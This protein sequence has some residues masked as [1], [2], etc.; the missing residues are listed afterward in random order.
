M[1]PRRGCARASWSHTGRRSSR[2]SPRACWPPPRPLYQGEKLAQQLGEEKGLVA[3]VRRTS[4]RNRALTK[5][6]ALSRHLRA[7]R[8]TASPLQHPRRLNLP[9]RR[10][11]GPSPAFLVAPAWRRA[12]GAYCLTRILVPTS[13]F[14]LR[15]MHRWLPTLSSS[16]S[17]AP[18]STTSKAGDTRGCDT[19]PHQH[20]PR[21]GIPCFR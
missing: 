5:N 21:R 6:V 12:P 9:R 10:G 15:T 14:E 2:R 8:V 18:Q 19:R 7:L 13:R 1:V 16:F 3:G 20:V 4:P 17:L 11:P